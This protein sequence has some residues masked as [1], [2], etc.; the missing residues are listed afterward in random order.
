[1]KRC[2]FCQGEFEEYELE[3]VAEYLFCPECRQDD[4][5]IELQEQAAADAE[6]ICETYHYLDAWLNASK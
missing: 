6:E 4:E 2:D 5:V 1:M 3:R